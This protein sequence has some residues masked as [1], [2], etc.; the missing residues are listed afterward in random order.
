MKDVNP[1]TE[2][3]LLNQKVEQLERKIDKLSTDIEG[4]VEAWN[5]SRGFLKVVKFVATVS[6]GI[7]ALFVFIKTGFTGTEK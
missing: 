2:I 6:A 4:L 1:E 3:A 5:A 7:I